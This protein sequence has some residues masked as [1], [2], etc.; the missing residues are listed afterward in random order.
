MNETDYEEFWN[1]NALNQTFWQELTQWVDSYFQQ[2]L[3]ITLMDGALTAGEE[4]RVEAWASNP[5]NVYHYAQALY[6]QPFFQEYLATLPD[7]DPND[8]WEPGDD[9]AAF[10]E[11]FSDDAAQGDVGLDAL[12]ASLFDGSGD[13]LFDDTPDGPPFQ[14]RL[15]RGQV[16]DMALLY[17]AALDREPDEPGLN[18]FVGNMRDGQSLQDIARSFYQADEFRSQFDDFDDA[19]YINQL[20]ENVLGRQADRAGIDYWLNDIQNN[21]RSHAEVLV[22]FAQSEENRSNADAWL[23][24]LQF[25]TGTDEWVL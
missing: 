3:G 2:N 17:E 10:D 6:S 18:Y 15:N 8:G 1:N 5:D 23:A 24:G 25:D 9:D 21:G 20:Y 7:Y 19:N 22:S 16:E 12:F 11:L 13:D 14:A 4:A